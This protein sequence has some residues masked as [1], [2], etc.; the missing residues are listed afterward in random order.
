MRLIL[1]G[2]A[3]LLGLAI[4]DLEQL[5]AGQLLCGGLVALL[6]AALLK[7]SSPPPPRP[8]PP[9]VWFAYPPRALRFRVLPGASP[10]PRG[11][12]GA[13]APGAAI[14]LPGAHS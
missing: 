7:L 4:G 14:P 10:G 6:G 8:V 1:L 9:A 11:S 5:A 2:S 12:G 13:G 3:A